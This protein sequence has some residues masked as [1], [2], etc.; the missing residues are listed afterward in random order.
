MALAILAIRAMTIFPILAIRAHRQ[1]SD[2]I[3]LR[4][5]PSH[6]EYS[7]RVQCPHHRGA[8][9]VV[10]HVTSFH[11]GATLAVLSRGPT[12][13]PMPPMVLDPSFGALAAAA[14]ARCAPSP[15]TQRALRSSLRPPTAPNGNPSRA[16]LSNSIA[17]R[18]T[19]FSS[20]RFPHSKV[21]EVPQ[22]TSHGRSS[23]LC[24]ADQVRFVKTTAKSPPTSSETKLVASL[25]SI[26][27]RRHAGAASAQGALRT[28]AVRRV[29]SARPR[30]SAALS[31]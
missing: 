12:A 15:A 9:H 13:T 3:P 20:H 5:H 6:S 23:P 8:P 30:W 4:P 2:K 27:Q 7:L 14:L 17:T 25:K 28:R 19:R 11:D 18:F 21:R 10:P 24:F 29:L 26:D 16:A 1:G 31:R 22:F